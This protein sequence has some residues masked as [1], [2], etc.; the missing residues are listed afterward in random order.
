MIEKINLLLVLFYQQKGFS[1]YMWNKSVGFYYNNGHSSIILKIK[2]NC[3]LRIIRLKK[4]MNK[5][6]INYYDQYN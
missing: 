4:G 2:S 3:I 5:L 6:I 1:V